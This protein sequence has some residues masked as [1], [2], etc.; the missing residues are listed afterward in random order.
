MAFV[1]LHN[2][3]DFSILDGATRINDLVKRAVEFG[4][5]AVALTDHGYMFG[6]PN[7]DLA[8][9]GYNKSQVDYKQW[10]KDWEKRSFILR[11]KR[12]HGQQRV[13]PMHCSQSR[14]FL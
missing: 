9:S 10:E 4:M 2:H 13:R 14:D 12:R 1:H 8:C 6:I 3:S 5:P 7:F 11:R